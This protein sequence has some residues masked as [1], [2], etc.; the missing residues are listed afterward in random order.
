MSTVYSPT[1]VTLG[2]VTLPAD[3]DTI[4]AASVNTA[5]EALADG[6]VALQSLTRL[7][8]PKF[9]GLQSGESTGTAANTNWWWA[10][11]NFTDTNPSL[12]TTDGALRWTPFGVEFQEKNATSYFMPIDEHVADGSV[13]ASVVAS[14]NPAAHGALPATMPALAVIRM[15]RTGTADLLLSTGN[16]W[17]TDSSATAGAYSATHDITFTPNQNA[18]IDRSLY[19]YALLFL[20]EGGANSELLTALYPFR[21]TFT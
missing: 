15:N 18:T 7:V 13:L 17:A 6:V 2:D 16:G 11:P 3:G 10:Y 5:L 14:L 20:N 1:A 19:S 12:K 9:V 8:Y 4:D 21:L